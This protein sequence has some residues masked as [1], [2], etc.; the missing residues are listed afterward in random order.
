M[1]NINPPATAGGTDLVQVRRTSLRQSRAMMKLEVPYEKLF[2][3]SNLYRNLLS[4]H[5]QHIDDNQ[6]HFGGK[7]RT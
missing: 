6:Q 2:I 5:W 7:R 1:L 3:L 4:A